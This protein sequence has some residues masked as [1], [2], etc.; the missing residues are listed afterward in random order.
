MV[1]AE[2]RANRLVSTFVYGRD[3]MSI[4]CVVG[5]GCLHLR[6]NTFDQGV[7]NL[8]ARASPA[9]TGTL[10]AVGADTH[11]TRQVLDA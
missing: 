8:A 3:S 2:R 11:L 4:P 1:E 5:D 9:S 7:F 6:T 10:K